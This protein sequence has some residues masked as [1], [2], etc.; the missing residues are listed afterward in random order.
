MQARRRQASHDS[1]PFGWRFL[2]LL[3][4]AV[5]V[6]VAAALAWMGWPAGV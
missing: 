6:V 1:R 4:I 3:L 2:H 5:V